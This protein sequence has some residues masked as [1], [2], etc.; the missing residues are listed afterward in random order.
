MFLRIPEV[1]DIY[2]DRVLIPLL[3]KACIEDSDDSDFELQPKKVKK[4]SRS[5]IKN[6]NNN[7][8]R[9][10]ITFKS[11]D[12]INSD[13]DESSDE[14]YEP[15]KQADPII[16]KKK[17]IKKSKKSKKSKRITKGKHINNQLNAISVFDNKDL[18]ITSLINLFN[19]CN[20]T[21]KRLKSI[22]SAINLI[23]KYLID[24]KELI[25]NKQDDL[26]YIIIDHFYDFVIY[27][28]NK[29]PDHYSIS[30]VKNTTQNLCNLIDLFIIKERSVLWIY[31]CKT[32][33]TMV[34]SQLREINNQY[35][36]VRQLD[37]LE[38]TQISKNNYLNEDQWHKLSVVTGIILNRFIKIYYLPFI[39]QPDQDRFPSP[40]NSFRAL[41]KKMTHNEALEFQQ[42]LLWT[43]FDYWSPQ[44]SGRIVDFQ[45][46]ST[47]IY[48][49][50]KKQ[51]IFTEKPFSQ[52]SYDSQFSQ[53]SQVF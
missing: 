35:K 16:I 39:N 53:D 45:V 27:L 49:Q 17:V 12:T 22:R 8:K 38:I 11:N 52:G 15:K 29:S 32:L 43:I 9:R 25:I 34:R 28:K 48:D 30:H 18:N 19:Q 7:K 37:K 13:Y 24:I 50:A 51:W 5:V 2:E 46:G 3:N 4:P 10:S 33:L 31:K 21:E 44:R 1:N 47:L 6:V 42:A 23:Y 41:Y 40:T 26:L 14:D 20:Y 36:K